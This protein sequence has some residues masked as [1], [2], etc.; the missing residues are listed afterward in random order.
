MALRKNQN[1][2]TAAEKKQFTDAVIA[3]KAG[4]SP[5][6]RYDQ[7]VSMHYANIPYGHFGPAFFA[8]HREFLIQ[9]EQALQ[10]I[11]NDQSLALPYWDWTA[12][13]SATSWWPFTKDF[14]GG[15]G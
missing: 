3:L 14:L 7:F 6:N 2:L 1:S 4:G 15:N 5:G 10:T 8:W 12:N 13:Q 11:M 9:F